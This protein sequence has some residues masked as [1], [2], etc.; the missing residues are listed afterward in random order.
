MRKDANELRRS[1]LEEANRFLHERSIP[2]N[3][4][5]EKKLESMR[6]DGNVQSRVCELLE[7][8]DE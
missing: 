7:D 3:A 5:G 8:S 1:L 4:E 2:R 6:V